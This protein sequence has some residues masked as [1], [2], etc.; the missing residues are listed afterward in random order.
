MITY[1]IQLAG[2]DYNQYDEKGVVY[3]DDFIKAVC[4]FPWKEQV[5]KYNELQ[6]GCSPTISAVNEENKNSL[7]I[8]AMG[9]TDKFHYLIGH[10]HLKNKKEFWGLG[11]AKTKR[12]VEI[13][14]ID[15]LDIATHLFKLFFNNQEQELQKALYQEKNIKACW[16]Q[17]SLK[18]EY[19]YKK[20]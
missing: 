12:W 1:N 17:I 16:Q 6:Q 10:V 2:Y 3:V 7:W 15:S 5:E 19:R 14:A 20:Q 8:S 9:A 13:Y 4:G 11:K 18:K